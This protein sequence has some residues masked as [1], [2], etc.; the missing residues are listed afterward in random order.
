MD[1]PKLFQDELWSLMQESDMGPQFRLEEME[2]S[3]IN[4]DGLLDFSEEASSSSTEFADSKLWSGTQVDNTLKTIDTSNIKD[5]RR[6]LTPVCSPN[7]SSLGKRDRSQELKV[8][9]KLSSKDK[10]PA[11]ESKW[12]LQ[13]LNNCV[14]AIATNNVQRTQHLMWVLNDLGCLTGDANQRLAAYGLKAL[15]GKIAGTP[16]AAQAYHHNLDASATAKNFHNALLKFHDLSPWYQ[17]VYTATSGVLLDAFEGKDAIHVIDIGHSQGTQWPTLIEG[18]ATRPSGP[19]SV[20]K[21]TVVED[22]CSGLGSGSEVKSRLER[23]AKVM[24]LNMELRMLATPLHSLTR[25]A[26]AI[27][28]PD[29]LAVCAHFRLNHI[30]SS[31]R[32]EFLNFVR[33]ELEPDLVIVGENDSDNTS[34]DFS[35]V[36]GEVIGHFWSFLDSM[37]GAFKGHECEERQIM[38]HLFS[39]SVVARLASGME[40]SESRESWNARMRSAGF[41]AE[42][43]HDEIV[44][45]ARM[46]V[47]K[48]DV[49]WELR[50]EDNCLVLLWKHRPVTFCSVW[51]S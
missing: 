48:N 38:E 11:K 1:S 13:L 21:L 9:G 3:D 6:H 50:N 33:V 39:T 41:E 40:L 30:D 46:L 26:F 16:T 43:P 24:G 45:T 4:D 34:A 12:A 36:A 18:L 28:K 14:Q 23:F 2:D 20:F 31:Q 10:A 19:P 51:K 35:T 22:P 25:D 15:F 49:N 8:P 5:E 29:A 17:V 27:A 42:A 37:S 7:W 44:E 47:K 32:Q